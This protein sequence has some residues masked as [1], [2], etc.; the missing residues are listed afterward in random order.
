MSRAVDPKTFADVYEI[1]AYQSNLVWSFAM[2]VDANTGSPLAID[3]FMIDPVHRAEFV[4][5]DQV[6]DLATIDFMDAAA[7]AN[8]YAFATMDEVVE[9]GFMVEGGELAGDPVFLVY[10]V[11]YNNGNAVLIDA[12]TGQVFQ[13]AGDGGKGGGEGEAGDPTYTVDAMLASMSAAESAVGEG[14]TVF[15]AGAPLVAATPED[16]QV[17]FVNAAGMVVD[18]VTTPGKDGLSV[19][20]TAPYAPIDRLAEDLAGIVPILSTVSVTPA[21]A[22]GATS[23][24]IVLSTVV[25]FALAVVEGD[26]KLGIPDSLVW[27]IAGTSPVLPGVEIGITVAASSAAPLNL[28]GGIAPPQFLAAD[29]DR[30]GAIDGGDLAA[31][32]NAWGATYPPYDLDASGAVDGGDLAAILNSW[33]L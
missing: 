33:G 14:W 32:L 22:L 24:V 28:V 8:A 1:E 29:I 9:L 3:L 7:T 12:V 23:D 16:I 10:E 20:L 15:S 25:E 5:L 6:K 26:P 13:D 19:S 18:A 2:T 17:S 4:A 11:V 31:V 27:E 21:Q 30:S